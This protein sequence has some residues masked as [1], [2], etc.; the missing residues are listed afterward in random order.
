LSMTGSPHDN[1]TVVEYEVTYDG[2]VWPESIESLIL[3]IKELHNQGITPIVS[4]F[5]SARKGAR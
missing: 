1:D 3:Q 4:V 2:W 5:V